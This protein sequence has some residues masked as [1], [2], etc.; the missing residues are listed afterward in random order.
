METIYYYKTASDIWHFSNGVT[1][2][3]RTG[4]EYKR[5]MEYAKRKVVRLYL[6]VPD[7]FE[8]IKEKFRTPEYW[9]GR[10][11]EDEYEERKG[12]KE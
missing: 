9:V 8:I 6:N 12:H 1:K 2:E 4:S 3:A 11:W 5:M 10:T 7:Q